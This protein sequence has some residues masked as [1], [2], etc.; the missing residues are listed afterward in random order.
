KGFAS[1][2]EA[3]L[4]VLVTGGHPVRNEDYLSVF[5][6]SVD[7]LLGFLV[8]N[9]KPFPIAFG[10]ILNCVSQGRR[11][12]ST[13]GELNRPEPLILPLGEILKKFYLV[14]RCIRAKGYRFHTLGKHVQG[15]F[16]NSQILK[17]CRH[18]S[19]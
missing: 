13:D 19:V 14:S 15:F 1:R 17:A 6:D 3:I 16:G 11:K 12:R 2:D 8:L 18:I 10:D 7:P 9:L 5:V 4:W